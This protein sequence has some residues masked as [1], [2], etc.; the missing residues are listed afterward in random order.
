MQPVAQHGQ[1]GYPQEIAGVPASETARTQP[2]SLSPTS[3]ALRLQRLTEE[4]DGLQEELQAERARAD[5]A[6][7]DRAEIEA[8]LSELASTLEGRMKGLAAQVQA[9]EGESHQ[10]RE[11]RDTLSSGFAQ[12]QSL[13]QQ[14]LSERRTAAQRLH[15]LEDA[16]SAARAE[17]AEANVA[18]SQAS[19]ALRQAQQD[20]RSDS[21]EPVD[22][23]EL[24]R[25]LREAA[26]A[27]ASAEGD[28]ASLSLRYTAAEERASTAESRAQ[29]AEAAVSLER[30][31]RQRT[32]A[33][34]AALREEGE[35][36]ARSFQGAVKAAAARAQAAAEA[37]VR[38]IQGRL[39]QV[40]LELAAARRNGAEAAEAAEAAAQERDQARA[41]A[42]AARHRAESSETAEE[43]ARTAEE[44]GRAAGHE[45]HARR[46]RMQ[47]ELWTAQAQADT[48]RRRADEAEAQLAEHSTHI[49]HLEQQAESVQ[50]SSAVEVA[51][52]RAAADAA[53][54]LV[55]TA[56]MRADAAQAAAREAEHASVQACSALRA[57]AV[58]LEKQL[59]EARA[60]SAGAFALPT[61]ADV[62]STLGLDAW[63]DE[64]LERQPLKEQQRTV[65]PR[66]GRGR[67]P[68]RESQDLEAGEARMHGPVRTLSKL[69]SKGHLLS[70]A[71]LRKARHG[72]I[73]LR[74]WLL[75]LYLAALHL[76]L[77]LSFTRHE[78]DCTS[79]DQQH[80]PG[81]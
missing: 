29:V 42:E 9:R 36:R 37:Q 66:R 74:W 55:R 14:S 34:A 19:T 52:W 73:A 15:E 75:V 16:L 17:R 48:E 22:T 43:E 39:E 77:I 78:S 3:M 38:S 47:E 4:C 2:D 60:K 32:E 26:Q 72:H 20:H 40:Q 27:R 56:D 24:R 71:T 44:A 50:R 69:V 70:Q 53:A 65:S 10:L 30:A 79:I 58:E 13:L 41:D 68:T 64:R 49:A 11:E 76:S 81:T 8:S 18:A 45:A 57:R 67:G 80:L 25:Q 62:L 12:V 6:M 21:G 5:S 1:Q 51:R 28:V 33:A 63:R 54:E 23:A 46:H 35:R 7:R 59:T 61:R 31:A